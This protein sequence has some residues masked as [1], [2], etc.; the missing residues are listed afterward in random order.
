MILLWKI[1]NFFVILK[2][3]KKKKELSEQR[4]AFYHFHFLLR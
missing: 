4:P 3:K 1:Y 2:K